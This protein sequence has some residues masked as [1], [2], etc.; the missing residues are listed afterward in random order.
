MPR[1]AMKILRVKTVEQALQVIALPAVTRPPV[2][3]DE[4][5]TEELVRWAIKFHVYSAIA[6]I[7]TV[8]AGLI[9]V[10]DVGNTPSGNILARHI[11]EWTAHASYMKQKLEWHVSEQQWKPAFELL[12][13]V[14]TGNSWAKKHGRAYRVPLPETILEPIRIKA[15]L[16]AYAK[17]Q[18]KRDGKT[19]AHDTYGFLSEYSHPNSACLVQ[20][21]EYSGSD[22]YFVNPPFESTFGGINAFI[23]EWL[24]FMVALLGLA[25]EQAIRQTLI[26][27]LAKVVEQ[28]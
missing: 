1:K 7:R 3:P 24:M 18:K 23:L 5:P 22:C 26:N 6:H 4:E 15:L 8:L 19:R 25:N 2:G 20:Y 14:D 13:R 16:V 10:A 28:R 11:F 21:R 9:T 12:S 27:I 17:H